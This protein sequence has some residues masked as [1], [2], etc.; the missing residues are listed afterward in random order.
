MVD[1]LYVRLAEVTGHEVDEIRD[2]RR[3]RFLTV[4][5]ATSH[6]LILGGAKDP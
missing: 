5:Q 3:N 1:E 2:D 6:G 4:D